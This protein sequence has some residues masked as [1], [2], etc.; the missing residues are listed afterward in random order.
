[1][2]MPIVLA[3]VGCIVVVFILLVVL[4]KFVKRLIFIIVLLGITFFIYGLF[5]P[6][7][8]GKIRYYVQTFPQKIASFLG[9]EPYLSYKEFQLTLPSDNNPETSVPSPDTSVPSTGA[10]QP[11]E[12]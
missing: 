12:E 10:E 4:R 7:G 6:S 9:G 8:A 5:N 2:K 11:K 1:M 3:W